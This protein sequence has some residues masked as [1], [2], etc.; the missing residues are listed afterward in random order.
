MNFQKMIQARLMRYLGLSL[1][2]S[3]TLVILSASWLIAAAPQAGHASSHREAP[4]ISGDPTVDNLDVYAFVSPDA[5]DTVTLI[6]TWI[7]FEEPGGGPNFYHFDPNAR[8]LINI[9]QDGDTFADIVYEWDF[10]PLTPQND[11]TFLY[12]TGPIGSNYEGD[13]DFNLRQSYTVRKILDPGG[14]ATVD[15]QAGP[16]V[17]VPD[18]IGPR[19]TSNY[20]AIAASAVRD[21]GDGFPSGY[22]E[23]TGQRDDPFFVD[24]GSIFD[25]AGLRPFNN[26]H[27]IPLGVADG[28]DVLKGFNAH[29]TAIQA[30]IS[31]IVSGGCSNQASDTDCVIGVWSTAERGGVQVSRLGNPLVNEVV[32]SLALKDVFNS[33][34]PNVDATVPAVVSRVT[35]PEL[36][37]LMNLLYGSALEPVQ[38]NSRDDLVTVFLQGIPSVNQQTQSAAN[39]SEQLRLNT[40]IKPTQAICEGDPLGLF[41]DPAA[42]PADAG[43]LTA[44]PN[45]R[46][47]EDDV[48]D[49]ALRAVAQGYG[50]FLSTTFGGAVPEFKNLSPNNLLGDGVNANDVPCLSEFPYMG[51][52]HPGYE[53]NHAISLLQY[54][55]QI[56][57]DSK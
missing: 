5:P 24:V 30:P 32:M 8:Y 50:D 41:N 36:A 16:F 38:E 33:V 25:L 27:A 56:R 55:P 1:C 14:A 23:F 20:E 47:L 53:N 9:D 15:F 57:K 13:S 26:V 11:A 7:P 18:N 22:K 40:A 48:T 46:R 49:M 42:G 37:G 17:M 44:F 51:A 31:D 2:F 35:D 19:S 43:D 3:L 39:P 45:G 12:N 4:L 28:Q 6:A 54:I 29:A 21:S 34:A 10:S 52:P